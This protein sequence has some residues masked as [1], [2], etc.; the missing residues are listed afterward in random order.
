MTDGRWVIAALRG[1]RDQAGRLAEVRF[2]YRGRD[3][4][5][6]R[7]DAPDVGARWRVS[8][9]GRRSAVELHALDTDTAQ[10]VAEQLVARGVTD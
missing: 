8:V 10:D 7:I 9:L 4:V 3:V 6:F 2:T 5:A 1:E